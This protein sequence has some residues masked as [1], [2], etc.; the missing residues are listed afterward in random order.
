MNKVKTDSFW[1]RIIYIVSTIIVFAIAFLFLG[2]RPDGM[3]GMLDVSGLPLVNATL[4]FATSVLLANGWIMIKKGKREIHKKIM[5]TAFAFSFAFLV[6]YV[7]YHWFKIGPKMYD[8][9]WSEVYYFILIT[10]IIM[11][12]VIVP[13]ALFTLYRGW[14]SQLPKHKKIAK[15]TLPIWLYVSVTGVLIYGMLYL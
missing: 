11:A 7:I 3:K 6:T 4:N 13:L 12:T 9:G 14:T 10:H 15:I 5:L 2:P 1:N 8:G